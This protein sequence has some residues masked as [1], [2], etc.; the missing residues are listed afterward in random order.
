MDSD[1]VGGDRDRWE[2]IF[3]TMPAGWYEAPPSAAMERCRAYFAAHRCGRILDVGC[4]FGRWAEFLTRDGGREVVGIDYAEQGIRAATRWARRAGFNARFVVASATRLPFRGRPF[5][6]VLAALVLDNLSRADCARAVR[7]LNAVL[8]VGGRGFFVF[9]PVLTRAELE[10][11]PDDNPSK[12]CTHV[13]YE[14]AELTTC[15]PGWSMTRR[16]STG[17]RLRVIEATYCG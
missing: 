1:D 3:A 4:G 7:A 12:G 14:D 17:E 9:S 15:L 6:G 2:R 11:V 8:R 13:V 16:G 5:D 10:A